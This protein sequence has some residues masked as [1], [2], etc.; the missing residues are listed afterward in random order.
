MSQPQADLFT[1][2][3]D[4]SEAKA[5][6][7]YRTPAYIVR[8]LLETVRKLRNSDNGEI[9]ELLPG[10]LWLD[11]GCGDGAIGRA[12][13][14]AR[15]DVEIVALDVRASAI[16]AL[17]E[18]WPVG[19]AGQLHWSAVVDWLAT[20]PKDPIDRSMLGGYE[21]VVV[22]MNSPFTLTHKFID[23]AFDHCPKA[24]VWSLQRQSWRKPCGD[25]REWLEQHWPE[26]TLQCV[27]PR[28]SFTGRGSD[29]CEYEWS[30]YSATGRDRTHARYSGPCRG[31]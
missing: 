19:R 23:A 5:A 7:Y 30:G 22:L 4:E 3:A 25:R 2:R 11:V 10:G 18:R 29:T 28:P 21:I 14:E 17:V 27:G 20:P 26:Y 12:V 6:E 16:R 1:T 13:V 24:I 8:Q 9:Y 31:A 15:P